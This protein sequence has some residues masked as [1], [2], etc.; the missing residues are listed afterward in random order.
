MSVPLTIST[1]SPVKPPIAEACSLLTP[2]D[3]PKLHTKA[4]QLPKTTHWPAKIRVGDHECVSSPVPWS[5]FKQYVD[6]HTLDPLGRSPATQTAYEAHKKRVTAEFGTM[7]EYLTKHALADFLA[8]PTDPEVLGPQDFTFRRND[9]P[10][11]IGDGVEH[12]VL[13]CRKRLQPGFAPP[14]EAVRVIE[15]RFGKEVEWRY[16]VNPVAKQSVPQLS[17]AHVFV[18]Q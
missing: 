16:F 13:W 12:W 15:E 2:P 14:E 11:S 9:F 18:Q 6:A 5:L 1:A 4:K 17:H 7:A 3:S 10:Y 8:Q